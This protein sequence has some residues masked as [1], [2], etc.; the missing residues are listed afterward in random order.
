MDWRE[1]FDESLLDKEALEFLV[2]HHLEGAA[3]GITRQ[4]IDQ[5]LSSLSEKQLYVFKTEVVDE[6]LIRKCKRCQSDVPGHDLIGVWENDGYCSYCADKMA[7]D[8]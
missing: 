5:G 1:D 4:V 2:Q 8:D 7:K 6:W 3:A